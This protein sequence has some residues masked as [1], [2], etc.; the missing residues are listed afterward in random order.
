MTRHIENKNLIYER[1]VGLF[2]W[3]HNAFLSTKWRNWLNI[4]TFFH[5]KYIWFLCCLWNKTYTKA[6]Y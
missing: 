5:P 2:E 1:N 4:P 6:D 3:K